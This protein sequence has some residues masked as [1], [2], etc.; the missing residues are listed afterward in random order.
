[1][2]TEEFRNLQVGD[3]LHAPGISAADYTEEFP[4][5]I[6]FFVSDNKFGAINGYTFSVFHEEKV[7]EVKRDQLLEL[8]IS[9]YRK[10]TDKEE[11]EEATK[12]LLLATDTAKRNLNNIERDTQRLSRFIRIKNKQPERSKRLLA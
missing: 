10:L 5:V 12:K 11:L 7:G 8:D 3:V 2:E 9:T 6:F 1:M 4:L